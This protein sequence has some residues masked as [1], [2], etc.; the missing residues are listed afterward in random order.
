MLSWLIRQ[1]ENGI[2]DFDNEPEEEGNENETT[3][4]GIGEDTRIG[5]EQVEVEPYEPITQA[6]QIAIA[7]FSVLLL[8]LSISAY[9]K[10]SIKRI[11][12]A[13]VAFGLFAIQIFFDYLEDAVE[14]FDTPY[15]DIIFYG[16][17]LAILV[18]FFMAIVRK[19]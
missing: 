11:L 19:K 17:T 12:Y 10:T 16:M 6:I 4:E 5:M 3:S 1:V 15:S 7:A 2:G 9:K 13:A 8:G 14:A 18:L